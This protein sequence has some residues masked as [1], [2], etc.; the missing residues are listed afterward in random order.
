MATT[1]KEVIEF[2]QEMKAKMVAL[3]FIFEN[4]D[5]NRETLSRLELH[6]SKIREIILGLEVENYYQGPKEND[7]YGT[8]PMWV[9]GANVKKEEIY[10]KI[11]IAD[12][13]VICI[14]FH[15][16]ENSIKYPYKKNQ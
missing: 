13:G 15:I 2:L 16:A 9:F 6:S 7:Q 1:E 4:R 14:S 11:T 8:N 10:I 5:K 12:Y 3:Q